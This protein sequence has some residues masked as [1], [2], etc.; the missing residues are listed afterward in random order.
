MQEKLKQR[1][2]QKVVTSSSPL[3]ICCSNL[4]SGQFGQS[5]ISVLGLHRS[6]EDYSGKSPQPRICHQRLVTYL[7]FIGGNE[8]SSHRSPQH[9]VST[10]KSSAI[11]RDASYRNGIQGKVK[12][13][14][15]NRN[16]KFDQRYSL[17][18]DLVTSF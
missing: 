12:P 9:P 1:D 6:N 2:K 15:T 5:K 10:D 4:T 7:D 14:Q 18:N 11:D 16:W 13:K 3:V 17:E 8:D